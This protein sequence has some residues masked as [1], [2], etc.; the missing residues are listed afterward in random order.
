MRLSSPFAQYARPRPESWRG[1]AWPRCAFVE[2]VDPQQLAVGGIE[3]DDRAAR[4]GRGVDDAVDHQRRRLEI[5]LAIG[6]E[7]IGLEA[8]RH[9]EP[10]EV[11]GVDLLERRVARVAEIA[12]VRPPFAAGGAALPCAS[13]AATMRHSA[14]SRRA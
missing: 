4:A 5:E 7:A 13:G 6:P 11:A 8:P 1:A 12:A 10:A 14:K 9:F 3:R 2:P